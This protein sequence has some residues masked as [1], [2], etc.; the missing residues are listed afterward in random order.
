MNECVRLN[1]LMGFTL[2]I[3]I[4]SI[5]WFYSCQAKRPSQYFDKA[6]RFG[7]KRERL[8]ERIWLLIIESKFDYQT[9]R[10][11]R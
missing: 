1:E 9:G 7:L 3:V 8:V 4:I 11:L 5:R 6:N 2:Y 10:S